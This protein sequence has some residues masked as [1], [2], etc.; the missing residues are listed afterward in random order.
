M[1]AIR[2]NTLLNK[3]RSP[4]MYA[5]IHLGRR[6]KKKTVLTVTIHFYFIFENQASYNLIYFLINI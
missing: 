3:W 2:K 6:F 1:V 5:E 4:W